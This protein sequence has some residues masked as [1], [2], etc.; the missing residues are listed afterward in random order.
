MTALQVASRQRASGLLPMRSAAHRRCGRVASS[1]PKERLFMNVATNRTGEGSSIGRLA[2][3]VARFHTTWADR[4]VLLISAVTVLRI[5]IAA[6]TGLTDT[7]AYYASWSRVPALSYYDHPPLVAWSAWPIQRLLGS[8]AAWVRLVPV[9]G[10]AALDGLVYRLAARLFSPRAGFFAVAIIAATPVFFVTAFLLNPEA[11]L[12]PLWTLFLLLLVDF[13]E[14]DEPWRPLALGAVIGVAFLAKYTAILAPPVAV[15]VIGSSRETRRWLRRR[16]LYAGGLVALALASPVI[17]WNASH[18]WPSLRLHLSD[19]MTLAAGETLGGALWR[20]G[21]AQLVYAQPVILPAL[22][23]VLC[24]A[25]WVARRDYRYRFLAATSLPVLAFLLTVMVRA[26]DSEPHWTM[27]GYV[28]L[29]VAAAG[30]LD[31]SRR[32][33]RRIA[34]GLFGTALVVSTLVVAGYAVHLRSPTL[35]KALPGYDPAADPLNETLGWDRLAAAITTRASRLGPRA[36]VASAHNVLCGHVQVALD[37]SPAV[38]CPSPRRTEYDFLERRSPPPDVPVVLVDN[39]RYP[40]YAASA[41]PGL[42]CGPAQDVVVDRSGLV[43]AR[44]HLRDCVPPRQGRPMSTA[45]GSARP[46]AAARQ[47]V[48][49]ARTDPARRDA[50]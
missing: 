37:D 42:E 50:P 19:R 31:E 30:F 14:N 24:Y 23:A 18:R 49:L 9:L 27:V 36:V 15:L 44:Y 48:G 32:A 7:E 17:A 45:R 43:V 28:P 11:L 29:I 47:P 3:R 21:S 13:R 5:V 12:V 20:V 39:D 33:A 22:A 40:A 8:S 6:T 25:L 16:S 1:W 41:L 4:A 2:I 26:G 46:A 10:A 38:Y 35:A 34:R